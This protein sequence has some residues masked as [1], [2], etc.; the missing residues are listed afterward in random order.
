MQYHDVVL[1][2]TEDGCF[3]EA[4][5]QETEEPGAVVS[6]TDTAIGQ[7]HGIQRMCI[8]RRHLI[9]LFHALTRLYIAQNHLF[10]SY[11]APCV[12]KYG[13]VGSPRPLPWSTAI[14]LYSC[15]VVGSVGDSENCARTMKVALLV[16][17]GVCCAS[18]AIGQSQSRGFDSKL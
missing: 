8:I 15:H 6:V 5:V 10:S 18:A 9:I 7:H 16:L 17:F 2:L 13:R 1:H 12:S 4:I 14:I 11:V 3:L